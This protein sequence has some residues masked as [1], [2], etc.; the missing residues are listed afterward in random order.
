LAPAR[1]KLVRATFFPFCFLV[2]VEALHCFFVDQEQLVDR[3]VTH[4]EASALP[5]GFS[6]PNPSHFTGRDFAGATQGARLPAS[7]KL[8][9]YLIH[10]TP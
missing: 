6:L 10:P 7:V 8:T 2:L 1:R 5:V 9:H 3:P 4:G